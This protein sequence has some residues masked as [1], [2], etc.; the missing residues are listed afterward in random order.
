M[1]NLGLSRV[2]DTVAAKH[3]VRGLAGVLALEAV[4]RET[5]GRGSPVGVAEGVD[6][7]AVGIGTLNWFWGGWGISSVRSS[8]PRPGYAQRRSR[9]EGGKGT[10][11]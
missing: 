11:P 9:R 2:D 6:P 8:S 5:R 3:P 7:P 4:L 10:E 1:V